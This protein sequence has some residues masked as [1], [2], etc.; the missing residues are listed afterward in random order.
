[1][2][3]R[4]MRN[5]DREYAVLIGQLGQLLTHYR[6]NSLRLPPFLFERIWFLDR[7]RGPE[8]TLQARAVVQGLIEAMKPCASA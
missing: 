4:R 7:L 5:S 1:M 2:I 3:C 8:R 6:D